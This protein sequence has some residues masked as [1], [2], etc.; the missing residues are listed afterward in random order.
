MKESLQKSAC[1]GFFKNN[2]DELV[3]F[4][5]YACYIHVTGFIYVYNEYRYIVKSKIISTGYGRIHVIKMLYR[6]LYAHGFS[7]LIEPQVFYTIW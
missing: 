2:I 7:K 1:P 5:I 3:Y 4:I 6:F